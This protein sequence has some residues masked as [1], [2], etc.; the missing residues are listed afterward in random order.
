LNSFPESINDLIEEFSRLPGIGRKTAQRLTFYILKQNADKVNLLSNALSSVKLRIKDCSIC[1]GISEKDY[2]PICLD[3]RRDKNVLCVVENSQDVFVFEK[4]NS[5]KGMYHVLGGVL[6]PLDGIGPEDLNISSL[7]LRIQSGMEVVLATNSS[8]EGDTT[9][10]YLTKILEEK[11]VK[12]TRLARGLPVGGDLD[13][14]DEATLIRAM[15][16]RTSV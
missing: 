4:T 7:L 6:S 12:V 11:D 16:G 10:L 1:H 15:E 8:V 5:F 2:C 14:I 3:T 13:Y 9:S